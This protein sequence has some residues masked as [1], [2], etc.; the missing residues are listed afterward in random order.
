MDWFVYRN[1]EL[2]CEDVPVR[3]IARE[4]GTPVYVYS[5]RT[6]VEHLARMREAFAELDPI[7]CF[8]VKSCQNVHIC[9]ILAEQGAGFDVVSGGELFRALKAGGDPSRIV[10]AG[11]G[12]TDP[13]IHQAIDARIGWFNVE[14]E[15]EIE[16]LQQIA[17]GR[18]VRVRAA[19]RINPDVDPKTH[20]HTTTGKKET[21]FGVD[22]ERA[23]RV[24]ERYGRLSHVELSGLHLHIGSPV[25]TVQPYVDAL[26][27]ALQLVEQLRSAGFMIDTLDI[28]GGFA[29]DYGNDHVASPADYAR[30]IVPLLRGRGLRVIMEPGRSIAANAGILVGTVLYVKQSGLRQFVI[31]DA[32]MTDLIRPVLYGAYHFV[33][34]VAPGPDNIPELRKG[35]L[36]LS[37]TTEVDVVGP[38][39]E[40]GDFLAKGRHLPA[41]QRGDQIAVFAAG[42]YGFVMSSQYNSRPR[43]PEVLVNGDGYRIIRRRETYEDLVAPEAV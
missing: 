7:I 21:K 23:R 39:C 17:A 37:G 41:V 10:Y 22:L 4:V 42:A 14:S 20:R 29:A 25:N 30:A 35:D 19:L 40:T 1:G 2:F 34:P 5:R 3:R 43:A 13:E 18:A 36:K 33:W 31:V 27:R 16:N 12:K 9:R 6:L 32:A 26:T 11:A 8:S 24:F 15:P 38:V 28:G